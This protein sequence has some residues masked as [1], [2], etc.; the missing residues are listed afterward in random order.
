M[1]KAELINKGIFVL[2]GHIYPCQSTNCTVYATKSSN[3][4]IVIVVC[5]PLWTGSSYV[6]A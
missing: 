5:R 1:K 2:I 6:I 4:N 3:I